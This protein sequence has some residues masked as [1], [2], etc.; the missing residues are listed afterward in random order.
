MKD[1]RFILTFVVLLIILVFL[2]VFALGSGKVNLFNL[3][4]TDISSLI[5]FKVRL[6]RILLAIFTGAALSVSGAILQSLLNNPLADSYT[7]GISSGAAFGACLAIYINITFQTNILIQ[8][9]AVIF[10][11]LVLILVLWLSKAREIMTTTSLVLAG[12]IVG[13]VCQAGVSFLKAISEENSVAIIYWLMGNLG[14]KSMKQTLILGLVIFIGILICIRYSKE[15][16]IMSLGRREAIVVG[17][18]YDKIYKVLLINCT[19]MTAFCVSLCGIIGFVGLIVPHLTRLVVGADNKKIIPI[20]SIL[21]AVLLLGAD[22]VTRSLLTHEL[23]VGIIT[24]MLGG[25]FFCYIFI[26]KKYDN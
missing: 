23:P 8:P 22:T 19:L 17:V 4:D 13:S 20:C 2:S 10:S 12:I 21:G 7:L 3:N 24:T 11:I 14:S 9:M 25:P 16:N 26:T 6:P 18:D 5:L 15:L 1:K